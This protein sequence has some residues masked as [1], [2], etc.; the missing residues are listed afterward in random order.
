MLDRDGNLPKVPLTSPWLQYMNYKHCGIKPSA[1]SRHA[2]VCTPYIFNKYKGIF[3]LTASVG[4]KAELDYLTKTV[5]CCIDSR[6][7]SPILC[8]H[9]PVDSA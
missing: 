7:L 3:G 4:G 2:C 8:G 6:S 1:Q 5:S 9:K